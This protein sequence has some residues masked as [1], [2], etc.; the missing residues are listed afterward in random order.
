MHDRLELVGRGR[1]GTEGEPQFMRAVI[2]VFEVNRPM[3]VAAEPSLDFSERCVSA[4]VLHPP[5]R[6]Y[7]LL[8]RRGKRVG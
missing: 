2:D 4:R 1:G 6:K 3:E 5:V 7:G 8:N